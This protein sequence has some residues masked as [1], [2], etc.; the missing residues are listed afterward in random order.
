MLY[1]SN[2]I[3][4][5][6]SPPVVFW[7][8]FVADSQQPERPCRADDDAQ[9]GLWLLADL[10]GSLASLEDPEDLQEEI[11][12]HALEMFHCSSGAVCMWD[13]DRACLRP[14][15]TAGRAKDFNPEQLLGVP[16]VR[17][18]VLGRRRPHFLAE[19]GLA[20]T[21]SA[22]GWRGMAI[23]PIA[24]SEGVLGLLVLGDVADGAT[25]AE[26]DLALMAALGGVAAVAAETA[27]VHAQFRAQMGRSMT[28]AMAE[29]TRATAELQRLKTFNEELFDSVPVGIVVFDRDFRV[30]FRNGAA[31]RLWPDDRSII[32]A[33][34]RTDVARQDPDWEANLRDVLHMQRPWLAEEVVLQRAGAE[35]G[36]VDLACAPLVS[37]RGDVAGGVL[38]IEDAT[39]RIR[40]EQRLAVSERLAGVGRLAAMVAH[41]INNPL[42]GIIRLVNLARRVGDETGDQRIEKY[43]AD[44]Q[45]GLQRLVTIVRDLLDFSRS[46]AGA[47][48][49][50]PICDLL[51][52]A[53]QALAPAAERGGVTVRATC[54]PDVPPLKSGSLYHVVLNLVKNA[55]E[56]APRGGRV[57]VAARTEAGVLVIEVA[58]TGPGLSQDALAHLFEPFYS[59]KVPGKGT[60]LGL[61][62]SKD[63]VEKQGGTLT[64]ANRPDGGALL[65]VRIPI[66]SA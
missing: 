57:D 10:A 45:R 7:G 26:A 9:R 23:I 17:D 63:L 53:A 1:Y 2:T 5:P 55:V 42:D 39:Q 43:L 19:P 36:R 33:A 4:R 50:M 46:A 49:P 28:E 35:A 27:L 47:V 24:S 62:I 60:G 11:L 31:D 15:R 14:G 56:A 59:L 51:T 12:D 48:E 34:R 22:G 65:T 30:T 54:A 18:S 44:A 8:T 25:F 16:E 3:R 29:L 6:F 66:G 32:A 41:E 37:T 21:S 58:D 38:V 61:V 13:E 40:M 52:E 64:A 20:L